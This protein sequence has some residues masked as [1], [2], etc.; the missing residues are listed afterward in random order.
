VQI[1][2]DFINDNNVT[3]QILAGTY[4][5][6]AN[7]TTYPQSANM[8]LVPSYIEPGVINYNIDWNGTNVASAIGHLNRTS[9]SRGCLG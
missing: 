9:S 1:T 6:V 7:G 5:Q 4:V 8:A 3:E 2:N